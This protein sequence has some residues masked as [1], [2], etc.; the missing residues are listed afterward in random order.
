LETGEEIKLQYSQVKEAYVNKVQAYKNE[1]KM[2][3][4][5]YKIDFVEADINDGFVPVLQNYLVKRNK[6]K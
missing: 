2:K 6:M 5:Q 3:C 1:L 4:L